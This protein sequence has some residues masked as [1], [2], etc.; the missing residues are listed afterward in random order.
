M[1][2]LGYIFTGLF[3]LAFFFLIFIVYFFFLCLQTLFR[4]SYK[5][6][7]KPLIANIILTF[8][9]AMRKHPGNGKVKKL[10]MLEKKFE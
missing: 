4:K 3:N 5:N 1:H 7:T 6:I 2:K 10:K 9:N 8:W